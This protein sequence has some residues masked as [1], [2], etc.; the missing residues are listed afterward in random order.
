MRLLLSL[1]A[2]GGPAEPVAAG[3]SV[4]DL[5]VSL[6]DAQGRAVGLDVQRGHPVLAS[7]F[8]TSCPSACPMLVS[9]VQ[10]VD[11]ALSPARHDD[12]RIVLVSL[13]PAHDTPAALAAVATERQLD[14]RWTLLATPDDAT[15]RKV[16]AVLDFPYR[17]RPDG[18][19]DHASTLVLLDTEGR[20]VDRLESQDP[21][22]ALVAR[23]ESR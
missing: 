16:S 23:I 11:A 14:E 5:D 13:D 6:Q 8:Y 4:Y 19:F 18:E 12:L 20:V 22:D 17:Q 21:V 9:R 3:P 1:L 2:C 10:A 7:M 15:V